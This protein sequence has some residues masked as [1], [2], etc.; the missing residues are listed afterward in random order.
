MTYNEVP[1][2]ESLHQAIESLGYQ[3]ADFSND[4]RRISTKPSPA[5]QIQTHHLKQGVASILRQNLRLL[6]AP[7]PAHQSSLAQNQMDHQTPSDSTDSF[8]AFSQKEYK[9]Y[10]GV[11]VANKLTNPFLARFCFCK[12]VQTHTL[13]CRLSDQ[14]KR[15]H[16]IDTTLQY[17]TLEHGN[18]KYQ[19]F[20][21]HNAFSN[22]S[23]NHPS[24]SAK[25]P[26]QIL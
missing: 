22:R 21:S 1:F 23:A 16:P 18:D 12:K 17:Q 5:Y 7:Y 9:E 2:P 13:H 3:A 10:V 20:S 15:V 24:K 11:S 25:H 4:H 14:K 8:S 19:F 6:M 26:N